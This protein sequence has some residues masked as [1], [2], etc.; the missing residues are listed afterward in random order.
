MTSF[1][2]NVA[3]F[4]VTVENQGVKM[5]MVGG[6]AVNYHGYQRY[7]AGVDFWIDN[8]RENLAKLKK[9][10]DL[11]GFEFE[12]FPDEVYKGD[13]N[14]SLKFSPE[15]EM[16]LITAFS[17]SKSFDEVYA[18]SERVFF[19][20][21]CSYRVINIDDL[22]DNKSQ[23]ARPKDLLDIQELKRIKNRN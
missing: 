4:I 21:G 9:A 13:Q 18:D 7:S 20:K 12:D 23:S 14:I 16:E 10:L 11:L 8:S 15:L 6:T 3:E 2:Q 1:D 17:I 5:I 22:I 19:E